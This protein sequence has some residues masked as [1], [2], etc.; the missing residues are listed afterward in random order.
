MDVHEHT[1]AATYDSGVSEA[2]TEVLNIAGLSRLAASWR[3]VVISK[4]IKIRQWGLPRRY[5]Q[6]RPANHA[7]F[8]TH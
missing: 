1:V 7:E 8:L 4:S 3:Y 6:T 2:R 5:R